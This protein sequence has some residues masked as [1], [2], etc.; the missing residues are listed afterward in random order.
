MN[1]E[2]MIYMYNGVLFTHQEKEILAFVITWKN[3]EDVS[4]SL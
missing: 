2:N 3:L 4:N 1:E